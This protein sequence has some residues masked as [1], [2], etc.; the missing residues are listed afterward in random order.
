M[1]DEDGEIVDQEGPGIPSARARPVGGVLMPVNKLAIVTPYLALFGVIAAVIV[2]VELLRRGL[3][4]IQ[5]SGS[6]I[7]VSAEKFGEGG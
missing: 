2:A 1:I 6:E 7:L 4:Q 5:R 3:S